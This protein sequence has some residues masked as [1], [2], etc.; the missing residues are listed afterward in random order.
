MTMS[1][2][3]LAVGGAALRL[4]I[5]MRTKSCSSKHG[6]PERWCEALLDIQERLRVGTAGWSDGHRQREARGLGE[7]VGD[8]IDIGLDLRRV[9]AR[10]SSRR[11]RGWWSAA[12]VDRIHVDVVI[13][14]SERERH[15]EDRGRQKPNMRRG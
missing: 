3:T 12:V 5:A 8:D 2:A 6:R 11:R 7:V 4:G 13:L 9:A 10:R 15:V 14:Q 1:E